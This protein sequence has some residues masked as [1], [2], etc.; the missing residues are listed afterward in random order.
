MKHFVLIVI[1]LFL[2]SCATIEEWNKE[3]V[4]KNCNPAAAYNA[5]L[6]QGLTPNMT[7]ASDFAGRC[8][9]NNVAINGAYLKGYSEGI[10]SRPQ[11]ITINKNINV[12]SNKT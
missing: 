7:P 10:K 1:T 11:E 2:S 4:Q 6:T 8:P 3:W 9:V 5:G 12:S